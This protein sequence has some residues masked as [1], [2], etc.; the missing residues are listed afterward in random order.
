MAE[1][2][3]QHLA[4]ACEFV[5]VGKFL[6]LDFFVEIMGV[7]FVKPFRPVNIIFVDASVFSGGNFAIARAAAFVCF[8][9]ARRCIALGFAFIG[10]FTNENYACIY[11]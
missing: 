11:R 1:L 2:A 8:L 6:R 4:Q 3:V 9:K 10:V 7:N 5:F